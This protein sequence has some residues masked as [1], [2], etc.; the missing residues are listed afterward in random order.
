MAYYPIAVQLT[1]RDLVYVVHPRQYDADGY[2]NNGWGDKI[3]NI[4]FVQFFFLYVFF[5]EYGGVFV[6]NN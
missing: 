3:I 4:L 5:N 2:K 6:Q 1:C